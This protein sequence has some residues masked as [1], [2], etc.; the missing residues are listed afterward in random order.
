MDT[1]VPGIRKLEAMGKPK[2]LPRK[3]RTPSYFSKQFEGLAT[4]CGKA[5]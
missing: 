4:L 2:A 1:E 5:G 3:E